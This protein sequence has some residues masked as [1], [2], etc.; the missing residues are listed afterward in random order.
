M[1]A[2]PGRLLPR[3]PRRTRGPGPVVLLDN[4]DSF[5][6]NLAH[7]LAMLGADV[8]VVR[9]D[10]ATVDEVLAVRPAGVVVSPGPLS[11]REAGI[12]VALI[13][14][15]AAARPP[16]PVLGVCL[17]HQALGVA[18]GGAVRR[19]RRPVHGRA[20][21]IRSR[22]RGLLAGLPA[23]FRAARYHSLV[24]DRRTLP[25]G[26]EVTATSAEGEIMALEHRTLPLA[27]VQFH[28]ES[29][30]TPHGPA[31]LAAFLR[32]CGLRLR[33]AALVR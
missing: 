11:P 33:R 10:A 9:H 17:G 21:S 23:R 7:L 15:C 31:V 22:R 1:A 20:T 2:R 28:P 18:F 14:A 25:D 6:Q 8:A 5:T 27:G 3:L 4:Y 32:R 13:R 26:L 12:S 30:L 16:V 29:F 19:A 24:V